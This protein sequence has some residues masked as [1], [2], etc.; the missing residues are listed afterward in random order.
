M[1]KEKYIKLNLGCGYRH[2][3]GWLNVDK[4]E[5]CDP[6]M[7]VDLEETP[8]PW[9]DNSVSEVRMMH[10]LEQ[11]GADQ[12][13]FLNIM[14]E[15][16]R[17]C[18]HGAHVH[19]TA[20]Y[21]RHDSYVSDPCCCRPITVAALQYFDKQLCTQWQQKGAANTP[22]ALYAGVDFRLINFKLTLD[23]KFT[24]LALARKWSNNELKQN[25]E[26]YNNAIVSSELH[27]VV[28]KDET[29]AHRYALAAPFNLPAYLMA[30]QPNLNADR[31]VS[32]AI[33]AHGQWQPSKSTIFAKLLRKL[34]ADKKSLKVM[35]AGATVGWYPLL[36]AKSAAN[37][38]VECYE[39]LKSN[40]DIL[41]YNLE[42]NA[43][44]ERVS[45]SESALSDAP[46]TLKFYTDKN[47]LAMGALAKYQEG[48][49]E[50]E[51]SVDTLE[52][53]FKG[54]QLARLPEVVMLDV[55]GAEQKVFVGAQ[56]IFD[57]GWRP[58]IF[59]EVYPS[60]LQAF[61]SKPDFVSK[62][63]EL[64]YTIYAISAKGLNLT[65]IDAAQVNKFYQEMLKP[66]HSSK[67]MSLLCVPE[68]VDIKAL[69]A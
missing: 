21:P 60:K 43:L 30:V 54:K 64:K 47:N 46:G 13:T 9:D 39:P 59:T 25:L 2:F 1:A 28:V 34:A 16:Y 55:Q 67:Y 62:L 19:I 50:S 26:L 12:Q 23:E 63:L 58:I 45:V 22:L 5:A 14:K 53:I 17:V 65:L 41:R 10:V 15:L 31:E 42:L 48:M 32:G 3:E 57:R 56:K 37:I 27:L 36:A 38:T 52:N 29:D 4:A 8:W 24:K 61:G 69:V 66:K 7:Q 40:A 11:V 44:T 68:G 6:D 35:V 51:V 49:D 18:R 20:A 33:A